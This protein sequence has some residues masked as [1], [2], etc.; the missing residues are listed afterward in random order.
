MTVHRIDIDPKPKHFGARDPAFTVYYDGKELLRSAMPFY[1]SC[2]ALLAMGLTGYLEMYGPG[3][4]MSGDIEV[5]AG[6]MVNKGR[7]AAYIP[8]PEK[9]KDHD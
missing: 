2:R 8:F 9:E 6:F 7:R 5:N 1:D 3:L 4:R